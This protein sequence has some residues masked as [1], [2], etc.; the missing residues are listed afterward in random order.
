MK[1]AVVLAVLGCLLFLPPASA[2]EEE[3]RAIVDRMEQL[4]RGDSSNATI[5]M[6][7]QTP[8]YERTLTMDGQSMGREFA[9]FRILSPR[10][11]RGVSTLKRHEEMWNYFPKINKVIKVPPSMMMGSWMGSDFTNDDLVKE[12]QL[13]DAYHLDMTET[14]DH[15]N[16]TLVPKEDTVTVWGKIEYVISKEP[17]LPVAQV[18]YDDDGTRVRELTFS[19]PRDFDG[20]LMPSHLEMHPLNK[21]GHRTIVQ[22]ESITFNPPDVSED[23]FSLRNL[24]RRF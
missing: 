2:S 6:I 22:Y 24:K 14:L 8:N 13:I 7:V 9:F 16:V 23:T 20:K 19:E 10:K 1:P 5:T 15:Y 4:Y 17:M 21:P 18:F 11:D 12:T 3:A